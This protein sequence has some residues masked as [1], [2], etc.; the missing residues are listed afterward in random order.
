[1]R[2]LFLV[3]LLFAIDL[4]AW[5]AFQ[6]LYTTQFGF[7]LDWFAAAY[8]IL[9]LLCLTFLLGQSLVRNLP[10]TRKAR[11]YLSAFFFI[12]VLVKVLVAALALLD[13][14]RRLIVQLFAGSGEVVHRSFVFLAV[15]VA[16]VLAL[17]SLLIWGMVRN[18]YRY[19][20]R[21]IK[22]PLAGLSP[23]LHGLKLV[24]ISDIH[25]GTFLEN[26]PVQKAIEL[27]NALEPDLLFFSGDLVNRKSS[28]FA[29]FVDMFA[30]L[31]STYGA[32]S[33][34]GNHDYGDYYSWSSQKAKVENLQEL[35]NY[36]AQ[37]GWQLLR[38][39]HRV[40][41]IR[42][43]QLVIAGVENFSASGRFPKYGDLE[44]ALRG[45]RDEVPTILISHD[46]SH[47]LYE[48][49]P[50]FKQVG[51]TLSGHT[52]GFQFGIEISGLIKW[53][54][55][56]YVY[57]QWAGLYQEKDQYLYVNRGLGMLGYPGRVGILPEITF[58]ELESQ[59]R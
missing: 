23:E 13:D 4:Y 15:G 55:V 34:L 36:Q 26:A 30:R 39:E 52:H 54:P 16:I 32:F 8:V 9:S 38:N 48:V 53:S 56:K 47:W 57:K 29:P 46:P 43:A 45:A 28:E 14:L 41:E 50:K 25:A 33:V 24:H 7:G 31:R 19:K 10:F 59:K 20:V 11:A 1:M 22:V 49:V 40:M 2:S 51:L 18:P 12:A 5:Q 44:K 21:K 42:G 35:M 17:G 3:C 37:M 58:I 6:F 27:I